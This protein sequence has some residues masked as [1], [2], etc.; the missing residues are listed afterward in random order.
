MGLIFVSRFFFV[1]EEQEHPESP[2]MWAKMRFAIMS[3]DGSE[4]RKWSAQK[5]QEF[6]E[7]V[8]SCEWGWAKMLPRAEIMENTDE[9]LPNDT[10]TIR[11]DIKVIGHIGH[12]V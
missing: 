4:Y 7:N 5:P 11:C 6:R 1:G 9:L 12:A 10:L 8:V 2:R 3:K